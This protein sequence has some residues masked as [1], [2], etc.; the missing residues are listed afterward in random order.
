MATR[1]KKQQ[2]P[3]DDDVR[4]LNVDVIRMDDGTQSRAGTD[5]DTVEEYAALYRAAVEAGSE[6]PYDVLPDVECV[7]SKDGS[8]AWPTDGFH[9]L[10]GAGEAGLTEVRVRVVMVGTVEDAR[11]L[12]LSANLKH[13][14]KRTNADKRHVVEMAFALERTRGMSDRAIAEHCGVS[15]NFVSEVRRH[16]SSDDR[17]TMPTEREVLR[18]GSTYSM[19]TSNIGKPGPAPATP[20]MPWDLTSSENDDAGEATASYDPP[21]L[22]DEEQQAIGERMIREAA[23]K[24]AWG[25]PI[26]P[27]AAAAFAPEVLAEFR[28]VAGLL[29]QARQALTALAESPGGG[30]LMR[31]CQWVKSDSE[32]GGRWV[33][34]A[35]DNA[36]REI[37]DARPAVTDCPYA[38]NAERPHSDRCQLCAGLRWLGSPRGHQI[39]PSL[40]RAM[41]TH[42]GVAE[43]QEE[44]EGEGD[45]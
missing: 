33:L 2:T 45:A 4:V 10:L 14:L 23:P 1:K 11:W 19:N 26:Q 7:L 41:L 28:R 37:E 30:H 24:D 32:A 16:L 13:G 5:E 18:G 36:L 3:P 43:K 39:P 40:K 9:R 27:H 29:R 21:A 35:L 44:E 20:P 22:S 17:Y 25:I 31:R 34:A 8:K 42:Y 12:A 6:T 15:H 38:H